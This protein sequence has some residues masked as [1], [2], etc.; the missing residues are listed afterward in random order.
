MSYVKRIAAGETL[1]ALA[2]T[3]HQCFAESFSRAI[4]HVAIEGK[5]RA[6][7]IAHIKNITPIPAD[8][9]EPREVDLEFRREGS[10]FKYVLE[11]TP[12]GWK[13]SQVLRFQKFDPSQPWERVYTPR[14]KPRY[15]GHVHWNQ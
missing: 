12:E 14:D 4:V 7:V 10:H 9:E 6:F 8:A 1:R 2:S 15:P 5:S 3:S 11:T 13:I